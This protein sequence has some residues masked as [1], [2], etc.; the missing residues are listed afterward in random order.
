MSGKGVIVGPSGRATLQKKEVSKFKLHGVELNGSFN[1]EFTGEKWRLKDFSFEETK[2]SE[3]D[4]KKLV[5]ASKTKSE[6]PIECGNEKGTAQIYGLTYDPK[7][8]MLKS[9]SF[10]VLEWSF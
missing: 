3:T 6:V 8:D 9:I 1:L 10:S 2:I 5:E 4:A 7:K